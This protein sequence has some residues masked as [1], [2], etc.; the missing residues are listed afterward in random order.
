MDSRACLSALLLAILFSGCMS[1]AASDNDDC[2][3]APHVY[4]RFSDILRSWWTMLPQTDSTT[5]VRTYSST[6]LSESMSIAAEY[7]DGSRQADHCSPVIHFDNHSYRYRSS[8][9][10]FDFFIEK[11][12][13][14]SANKYAG[15]F[16]FDDNNM[17]V[18]SPTIVIYA[19][20]Y[21]LRFF[22]QQAP[23]DDNL[24]FIHKVVS[25]GGE[26]SGRLVPVAGAWKSVGSL[27]VRNRLFDQ[28]YV[29]SNEQAA[30][31]GGTQSIVKIW[32]DQKY[33]IVQYMLKDSTIW[34]FEY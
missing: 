28:V 22:D 14:T 30:N 29:V 19:G 24:Y 20:N 9:Y 17:A 27:K 21:M 3:P 23:S 4:N 34:S 13:F 11:K 8:L 10:G 5:N 25:P 31:T 12:F 6:G 15:I 2:E 1:F 16:H 32:L 18:D 26:E 7:Y 33:A